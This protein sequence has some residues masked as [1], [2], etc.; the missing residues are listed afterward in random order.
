M[1]RIRAGGEQFLLQCADAKQVVL[2]NETLQAAINVSLDLDARPMPTFHTLPRTRARTHMMSQQ[3]RI[4]HDQML[5]AREASQVAEAQRRSLFET[6]LGSSDPLRD[7]L[8]R[9]IVDNVPTTLV[10]RSSEDSSWSQ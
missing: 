9:S 8:E 5:A 6:S 3:A 1:L 2:L 7:G 10:P 4:R